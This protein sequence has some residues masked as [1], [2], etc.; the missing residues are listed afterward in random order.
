MDSNE[1]WPL[2]WSRYGKVGADDVTRGPEGSS[3]TSTVKSM[4]SYR[5]NCD[6]EDAAQAK[7]SDDWQMTERYYTRGGGKRAKHMAKD[8]DIARQYREFSCL[9]RRYWHGDGLEQNEVFDNDNS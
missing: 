4:R 5:T 8:I 1:D 2:F 6:K 7:A 9:P 3:W